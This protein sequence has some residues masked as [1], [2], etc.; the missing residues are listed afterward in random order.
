MSCDL[1]GDRRSQVFR[2][3]LPLRAFFFEKP[4]LASRILE[5]VLVHRELCNR[6]IKFVALGGEGFFQEG[7][8]LE[9]LIAEA[10]DPSPSEDPSPER[11]LRD[12]VE[13]PLQMLCC[14]HHERSPM[15]MGDPGRA[16]R[17]CQQKSSTA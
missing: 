11:K 9:G 7:K 4:L 2:E 6:L 8:F 10:A 14:S 1:C 17:L 16:A 3:D 5:L 15:Q 13:E 12:R